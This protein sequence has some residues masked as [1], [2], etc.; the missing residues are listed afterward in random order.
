MLVSTPCARW[1]RHTD[2]IVASPPTWTASSAGPSSCSPRPWALHLLLPP[3]PIDSSPC[4][5]ERLESSK[6]T[7]HRPAYQPSAAG[8]V[9][10]VTP[11][12]P[13][14]AGIISDKSRPKPAYLASRARETPGWS[15][16]A[17]R[18]DQGRNEALRCPPSPWAIPA[19]LLWTRWLQPPLQPRA[20]R[21]LHGLAH[22]LQTHFLPPSLLSVVP[23]HTWCFPIPP[24]LALAVL[25]PDPFPISFLLD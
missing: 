17:Q 5:R 1:R 18:Q 10:S 7:T 24:A 15:H 14:S 9:F 21:F 23:S 11:H 13:L 6:G 19:L 16:G 2:G 8:S 20:S 4:S 3:T 22:L 25:C 12:A